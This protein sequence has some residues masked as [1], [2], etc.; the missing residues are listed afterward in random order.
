MFNWALTVS[1][2]TSHYP[3]GLFLL[4]TYVF[5]W[6]Y[7]KL[8]KGR[9]N[10]PTFWWA[11][12]QIFITK[13]QPWFVRTQSLQHCV[14]EMEREGSPVYCPLPPASATPPGREARTLRNWDQAT[15]TSQVP[16]LQHQKGLILWP[17]GR[18]SVNI[19]KQPECGCKLSVPLQFLQEKT[20]NRG[21][22]RKNR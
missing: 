7:M 4:N 6:I 19:S 16:A 8:K 12:S 2:W 14:L 9:P 17:P 11:C 22:R 21:K 10:D 1:L 5:F 3:L 13:S 20:W 18:G 15:S